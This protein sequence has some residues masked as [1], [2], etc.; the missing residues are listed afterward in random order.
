MMSYHV[1]GDD[2]YAVRETLNVVRLA[3]EDG[4]LVVSGGPDA[5][6]RLDER[7]RSIDEANGRT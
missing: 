5:M 2:T 4:R 6:L 1:Y 3:R 7:V